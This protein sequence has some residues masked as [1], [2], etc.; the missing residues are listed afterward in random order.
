M[1]EGIL[2]PCKMTDPNINHV[3]VNLFLTKFGLQIEFV[4]NLLLLA[5]IQTHTN[6]LTVKVQRTINT[7]LKS[8]KTQHIEKLN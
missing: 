6:R 4:P 5:L 3:I 1:I 7:L 8:Q 2:V